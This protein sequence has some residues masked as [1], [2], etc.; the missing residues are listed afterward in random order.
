MDPNTAI[1]RETIFLSHGRP[2]DDE[3]TRWLCGRLT[4]RGYKVWADLEQLHGGDPF[5]ADIER[6]IR[7]EAARFL[8]LITRTSVTRKGVLDELAEASDVARKLK[9]DRFIVPL[10]GDDLPW[11]EFPIQLKR[12]NGLDF[13][14][15]WLKGLS[16]LLDTL[17]AGHVPRT[18]GDPEVAR[19]ASLLTASRRQIKS[20]PEPALLNWLPITQLPEQIHYFHS[21]YSAADLAAAR[22]RLAMPHA[23][24]DRLILSFGDVDSLRAC[25]PADMEVEP[26]YTMPLT[27]FLSGKPE[28]GPQMQ[29]YVAGNLLSD[30]LRQAL[31]NFLKSRDL[32]QFDRRWFVPNDWRAQNK[33]RYLKSAGEEGYRVL[34]GKSKELTWHFSV[35]ATVHAW[36]PRRI[37]LIP[38]VLFSNDGTTPLADQKSLRRSRCK[39]WWNDK[40]RDLLLAFLGELFGKESESAAIPLGGEA[41]MTLSARLL[42]VCL[43]ASYSNEDAYLPDEET[44]DGWDEGDDEEGPA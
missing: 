25:A 13:S 5:W 30:L 37:Q 18:T 31:E 11:S 35:S 42:R 28:R 17:D 21:S 22:P 6:T 19:V 34:V 20:S 41:T 38:H 2:E 32:I 8:I 16:E 9:D 27:H 10:K 43:A 24:H 12:L 7:T 26:R 3:L 4:A 14:S 44:K 15:D 23:P 1:T 33:G 40:W 36:E 39:L 29:S